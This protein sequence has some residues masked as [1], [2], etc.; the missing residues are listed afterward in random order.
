MG[1]HA[2]ILDTD[3]TGQ[4]IAYLFRVKRKKMSDAKL[5]RSAYVQQSKE[6]MKKRLKNL[7]SPLPISDCKESELREWLE[8]LNEGDWDVE[9][10]FF[11]K[12]CPTK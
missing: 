3:G 7:P 12:K 6:R 9:E 1:C 10:N 2:S 8:K 11:E 4:R 5:A